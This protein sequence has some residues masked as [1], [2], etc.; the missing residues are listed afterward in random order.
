M[1]NPSTEEE[2]NVPGI[3]MLVMLILF[4]YRRAI[5]PLTSIIKHIKEMPQYYL[6]ILADNEIAIL[7]KSTKITSVVT[8]P[9]Q[10][11][12]C[13]TIHHSLSTENLFNYLAA[14]SAFITAAQRTKIENSTFFQAFLQNMLFYLY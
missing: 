10:E 13:L 1:I 5:I 14:V 3:F 4:V 6:T 7:E 2:K 11:F 12:L 8:S 9:L